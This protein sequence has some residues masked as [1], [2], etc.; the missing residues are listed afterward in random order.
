MDDQIRSLFPIPKVSRRGFVATAT[1]GAGF[2]LAVQPISAQ[3]V[4]TTDANGLMAG[5][6]QIPTPNGAIYGYYAMPAT[7]GP[8]PVVVVILLFVGA[9]IFVK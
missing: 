9:A 4:I 8:F 1:V 5:D 2:A 7:G 3:T 6:A